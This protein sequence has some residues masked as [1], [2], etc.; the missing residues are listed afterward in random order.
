[1]H[2]LPNMKLVDSQDTLCIFQQPH[3]QFVHLDVR[4][5]CL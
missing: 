5:Y 3:L 4:W 2:H 1:M